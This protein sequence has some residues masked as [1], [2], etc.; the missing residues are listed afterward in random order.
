MGNIIFNGISSKDIGLEVETFP[1]YEIPKREYQVYHVPGRNG[2]IIIDSGTYENTYRTYKVSIATWGLVPYATK[3][4]QVAEWLHSASGYSRL[5]DS[6]DK[7]CYFMA[8][9]TD[10]VS[11]EN[12]F[13]EA[14]RAELKFL[15]KPQKYL[16]KGENIVSLNIEHGD[17]ITLYNET[18]FAALPF[19][20]V[21]H[22]NLNNCAV[23]VV[24]SMGEFSYGIL[25]S[26]WTPIYIDS[27]LQDAWSFD[28]SETPQIVNENCNIVLNHGEFIKLAPGVNRIAIAGGITAIEILPRWWTI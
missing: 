19:I 20:K 25:P 28:N 15:C 14:G 21:V 4:R 8:Y 10:Q 26:A 9:Y 23:S 3:M 17:T 5:E 1:T 13:D 11:I 27:E 16:K 22:S 6:Y 18:N 24:N 7:E 12:L 2:D